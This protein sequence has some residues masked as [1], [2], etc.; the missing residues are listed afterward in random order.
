MMME[1]ESSSEEEMQQELQ[2]AKMVAKVGKSK[3]IRRN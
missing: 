1:E 3:G 2:K